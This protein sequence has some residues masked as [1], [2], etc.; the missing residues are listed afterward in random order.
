[1]EILA[2]ASG[3]ARERGLAGWTLRDL[4]RRLGM[5]APSLYSYFASKDALHDA[6]FAQG[7]REL[8]AVEIGRGRDLREQLGLGARVF[9]RFCV[10]DPVRYQLL[11]QRTIPG[12]TPSEES[13]ALARAAYDHFMSPLAEFGLSVQADLDLVTGVVSGLIDQQ[14][15]NDP[16]GDRWVRLLD[17]AL[18]MLT[19]H[20]TNRS[21]VR[22]DRKAQRQRAR[23][24]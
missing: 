6:M 13:W 17:P 16:G 4:A 12:F 24:E 22:S 14:L 8:L 21:A 23:K 5:A 15:S 2:V 11:F 3:L 9:V 18:D 1:M 19:D 10:E 20:F 7:N